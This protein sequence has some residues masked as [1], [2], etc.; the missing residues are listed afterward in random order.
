MKTLRQRQWYAILWL[1]LITMVLI[2]CGAEA[3]PRPNSAQIEPAGADTP[4]VQAVEV[5]PLSDQVPNPRAQGDP[6]APIVVIEYG[7]YQ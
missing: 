7:D 6:S 2:A 4:P 5:P 1:M 3:P